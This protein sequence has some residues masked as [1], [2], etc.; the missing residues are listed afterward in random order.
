MT[1]NLV[2]CAKYMV[3]GMAKKWNDKTSFN[4]LLVIHLPRVA[5]GC[6]SGYPGSPWRSVHLDELRSLQREI[7][8]RIDMLKNRSIFE[9]LK[10]EAEEDL[11]VLSF[12]KLVE[13]L[14]SALIFNS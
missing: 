8:M 7:P 11:G 2:E 9:I 12:E 10:L 14:L 1:N 6:H 4:L 13:S 5:G 3:Q